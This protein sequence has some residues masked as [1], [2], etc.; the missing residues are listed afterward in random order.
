MSA[1]ATL[2][3]TLPISDGTELSV[4]D[5]GVEFPYVI[6]SFS[7]LEVFLRQATLQVESM[8]G[9]VHLYDGFLRSYPG[10][11]AANTSFC[12]MLTRHCFVFL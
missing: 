7:V 12:L 11:N 3:V 1:A 4:L 2:P 9:S 8:D 6:P 5:L 10:L